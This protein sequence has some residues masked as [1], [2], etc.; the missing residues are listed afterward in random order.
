MPVEG[1]WDCVESW[2]KQIKVNNGYKWLFWT[3]EECYDH[4]MIEGLYRKR[5]ETDVVK[6]HWQSSWQ[7]DKKLLIYLFSICGSN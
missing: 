2:S 3:Q 1:R 7:S 6:M 4:G 5:P